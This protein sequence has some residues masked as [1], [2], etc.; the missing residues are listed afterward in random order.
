MKFYIR[1]FEEIGFSP[2]N[3]ILRAHILAAAKVA[4]IHFDSKMSNQAF[5]EG[6]LELIATIPKPGRGSKRKAVVR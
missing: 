2:R 1:K 3:S 6:T 5:L 4:T